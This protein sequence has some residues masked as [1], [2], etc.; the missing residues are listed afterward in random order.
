MPIAGDGPNNPATRQAPRQNVTQPL[1]QTAAAERLVALMAKANKRPDEDATLPDEQE[2]EAEVEPEVEEEAEVV[3][4]TEVEAEA[5][6]QPEAEEPEVEDEAEQ[7]TEET[8]EEDP[9]VFEDDDG[10]PVTLSRAR[11]ERLMQK[12]YTQK[13][14]AV[15][16]QRKTLDAAIEQARKARA[17]YAQGLET[18]KKAVAKSKPKEPDWEKLQLENP[19]RYPIV[20]AQWQQIKEQERLVEEE[21]EALAEAEAEEQ[22]EKFQEFVAAEHRA[23]LQA[24]PEWQDEAKQRTEKQ[25]LLAYAKSKGFTQNE[26]N[27][28]TMSKLLLL[29]RTAMK[30]ER[31]PAPK[32]PAKIVKGNRVATPG[33]TGSRP[34]QSP[35]GDALKATREQLRKSGH[36]DDAVRHIQNVL[37]QQK[38]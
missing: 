25:A 20:W 33:N 34:R 1:T 18:L 9:V 28:F 30:A 11:K 32:G 13:T 27:L 17:D 2:A 26:L 16:E 21:A 19:D 6:E 37:M 22:Q 10:T 31:K 7:T 12:D 35:K 14:Q 24:I 36:R 3:E 4:E 23:V 38:G 5:E 29:L 15:A 8:E